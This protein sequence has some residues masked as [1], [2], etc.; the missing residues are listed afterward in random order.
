MPTAP[1][2]VAVSLADKLDTLVGFFVD[3]READR[4]EGPV[5][6]APR[7]AW[8]HRLLERCDQLELNRRSRRC[9]THSL[10]SSCSTGGQSM[11]RRSDLRALRQLMRDDQAQSV[12]HRSALEHSRLLRRPPQGPAARS[13]RPP[14]PDRRGVRARAARTISSACSRGCTRCRASSRRPRTAPTCSPA[15]SARPI[16]SRR[17]TGTARAD[18]ATGEEDPLR[19]RRSRPRR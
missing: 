7:R 2:T 13:R 9:S 3:R 12:G 16:S 17:R 6:A 10:T 11:H 1:V 14:R 19:G 15:T 18:R 8:R 5:R 4:L